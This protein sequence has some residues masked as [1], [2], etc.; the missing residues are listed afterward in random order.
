MHVLVNKNIIQASNVNV[1]VRFDIHSVFI[2][3]FFRSIK[4][5]IHY[6]DQ[7]TSV[8]QLGLKLDTDL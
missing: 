3:Q 7:A 2:L 1:D 8:I 5:D 4:E 6:H